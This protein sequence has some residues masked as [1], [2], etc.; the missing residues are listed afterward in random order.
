[1]E[2]CW[3]LKVRSS[4]RL[5]LGFRRFDFV[6]RSLVEILTSRI[7]DARTGTHDVMVIGAKSEYINRHNIPIFEQFFP[8]MKLV[9]L[10]TGHW[11]TFYFPRMIRDALRSLLY[12]RIRTIDFVHS[13]G[14]IFRKCSC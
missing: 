3:S 2:R 1:M 4:F 9:T 8:K 12:P 13:E 7:D 10:D 6:L 14:E 5:F 11:G